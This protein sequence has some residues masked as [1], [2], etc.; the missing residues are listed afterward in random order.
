MK[1]STITAAACVALAFAVPTAS[2]A[3]NTGEQPKGPPSLSGLANGAVVCHGQP[4]VNPGAAV[5]NK[6]GTHG[7]L[8]ASYDGEGGC[9]FGE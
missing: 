1:R 4:H 6:N 5:F 3:K 7:N 2:Q 9:S 8:T